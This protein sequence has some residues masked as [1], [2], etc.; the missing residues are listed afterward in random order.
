MRKTAYPFLCQYHQSKH[1]QPH[2]ISSSTSVWSAPHPNP[3]GNIQQ[4]FQLKLILQK[5]T[6]FSS[7]SI[8]VIITLLFTFHLLLFNRSHQ[9]LWRQNYTYKKADTINTFT[10][11]KKPQIFCIL[12]SV[13]FDISQSFVWFHA[14]LNGGSW[15]AKRARAQCRSRHEVGGSN[16]AI[17]KDK[18]FYNLILFYFKLYYL[19]TSKSRSIGSMLACHPRVRVLTPPGENYYE[20]NFLKCK[21]YC[22]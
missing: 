12:F 14:D 8:Q 9:L 16:L 18:L 13:F 3:G 4:S 1:R 6:Y 17:P 7:V 21:P 20:P 15:I 10:L 22:C 5:L 19:I 11:R 2:I